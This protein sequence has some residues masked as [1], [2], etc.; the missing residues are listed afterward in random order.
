MKNVP[1]LTGVHVLILEPVYLLLYVEKNFA[2]VIKLRMLRWKD[3][4]QFSMWVQCNHKALYKKEARKSK[5]VE[6][7]VWPQLRL[8]ASRRW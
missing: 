4:P 5:L 8:V 1:L 6:G 2:N 7:N 3:Y